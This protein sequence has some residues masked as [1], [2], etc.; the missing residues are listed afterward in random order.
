MIVLQDQAFLTQSALPNP[1]L[2]ARLSRPQHAALECEATT[3]SADD[4]LL[5]VARVAGRLVA[6]GVRPGDHIGLCGPASPSWVIALHAAG[7]VGATAVPLPTGATRDELQRR[8]ALAGVDAVFLTHGLSAAERA[9]IKTVWPGARYV[10]QLPLGPAPEERFW[11]LDETRVIVFTSGSTGEPSA[12]PLSTSQLL[13]S[14]FGSAI[15]LGHQPDDRW[16]SCLPFHHV[17]GLSILYR[18]AFY[19][20]TVVLQERFRASKVAETLDAGRASL[21]SLVPGMLSEVLDARPEVPFPSTLRVVLLGGDAAPDS[22]LA[23]CRELKVPVSLTWGMTET[24]SQVATRVPGDLS[25]GAGCGAPMPFARVDSRAGVLAVRGPLGAGEVPTRDLGHLDAIGRVHVEG[26]REGFVVSGGET[27]SLTEVEA[28]LAQHP[29][30]AEVAVVGRPDE[31]WGERPVAWIVP[32]DG[33]DPTGPE[34]RLWCRERLSGFKVPESFERCA[35]LPRTDL[36]KLA[37]GELRRRSIKSLVPDTHAA[38]ASAALPTERRAPAADAAAAHTAS[39]PI[40]SALVSAAERNGAEGLRD[41]L[42]VM[43]IVVS[44]DLA[45]L[46]QE[47][48]S[49]VTRFNSTPQL[50]AKS[51]AGDLLSQSGKRLR[52]LCVLLAARLGEAPRSEAAR[53][54]AIASELI[55]TATLLHDDVIDEGSERRGMPAAR[56]V[57]GNSASV[58]A[59]DFLF[60]EAL[61]IVGETGESKLLEQLLG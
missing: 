52:P 53:C 6:A 9:N 40:L 8:I 42:D 21:V 24:A 47:L 44:E 23:R 58:I 33:T 34:L 51:A 55:H 14:A 35:R 12:V 15:R 61:R 26:R 54:M 1:L 43:E 46:D 27:V 30:L 3:W 22:L 2:S 25:N 57:Y 38:A 28:V 5:G 45:R 41:R 49:L 50:A 19:G 7:W 59:G 18:C 48:Q 37:R 29:D 20:T 56:V 13:L 4:L 17:G 10:N 32:R 16:L 60:A 31:T 36:G 39:N 11:P